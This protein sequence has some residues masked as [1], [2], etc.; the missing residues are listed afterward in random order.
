MDFKPNSFKVITSV[1]VGIVI[2]LQSKNYSCENT[3]M[4]M[5]NEQGKVFSPCDI[6]YIIS[7]LIIVILIY[8]I[9]SLI[10]KNK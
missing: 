6:G 10:Q 7:G 8:I 9:W 1:L 4:T 2:Y 3:L 5:A